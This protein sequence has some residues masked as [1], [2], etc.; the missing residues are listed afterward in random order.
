MALLKDWV[1]C[2][3][4]YAHACACACARAR[5][6]LRKKRAKERDLFLMRWLFYRAELRVCA[7]TCKRHSEEEEIKIKTGRDGLLKRD[8]ALLKRAWERDFCW[9]QQGNEMFVYRDAFA[10]RER[11]LCFVKKRN[12]QRYLSRTARERAFCLQ[13]CLFTEMPLLQ[14]ND[15]FAFLKRARERDLCQKQQGKELLFTE[16]PLL[17]DND[18][19]DTFARL[20]CLCYKTPTSLLC[21]RAHRPTNLHRCGSNPGSPLLFD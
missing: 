2:V 15:I 5:E 16:M 3:R 4:T 21:F 6:N 12:R 17:Q 10:T 1:G 8:I 19:R 20:R 11:H 9:R 13:R 7:R 14:K 18:N